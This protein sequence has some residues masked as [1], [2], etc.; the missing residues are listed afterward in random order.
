MACVEDLFVSNVTTNS[1]AVPAGILQPGHPYIFNIT[2]GSIRDYSSINQQRFS[3]PIAFSQVA[4]AA[5][6]VA[7]SK[8]G[9]AKSAVKKRIGSREAVNSPL[10]RMLIPSLK[11]GKHWTTAY[12]SPPWHNP[13]IF[14]P[15]SVQAPK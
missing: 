14:Q 9:L 7:G 10:H 13:A 6:T 15:P 1:F 11:N 5:I 2:A 3:Y 8:A 12:D 4:S